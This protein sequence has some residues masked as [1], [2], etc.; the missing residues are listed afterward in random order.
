M[1][2]LGEFLV[3]HWVLATL[4]VVL[5]SILMS[6]SLNQR[7]SGM[8]PITTAQAVQLV[9]QQKGLF[10]DIREKDE[11]SKAHIAESTSMPL[12]TLS[13]NLGSL[14]NKTQPI[15]IICASGQRSRAAAKQLS[16][17]EFTEVYVLTGGLNSWKEAKLP[18]FS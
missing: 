8:T 17:N 3:N 6:D 2:N 9:N 7:I 14:K 11:F 16:K 5:S 15:I 13:D 10:L 1:E 12:S 18:L 4:F